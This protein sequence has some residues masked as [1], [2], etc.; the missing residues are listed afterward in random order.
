MC[1]AVLALERAFVAW[2]GE[3]KDDSGACVVLS[4][5]LP[6]SGVI[7][8]SWCGDAR[9]VLYDGKARVPRQLTRDHTAA[10]PTERERLLAAHVKVRNGRVLGVLEPTRSLGDLNLKR[11]NPRAVVAECE[12]TTVSV[13]LGAPQTAC[14]DVEPSFLVL[15][16]DGVWEGLSCQSACD[17]V[18]DAL[19]E[20]RRAGSGAE[21]HRL[22]AQTA[23]EDITSQA[24]LSTQDDCT[25]VVMLLGDR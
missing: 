20:A 13:D 23:A 10:N 24:R 6:D 22:A 15:A 12:C 11:L 2:A 25:A 9:A 7:V 16:T 3:H 17:L 4:L 1:N 19:R 8:T 14:P 5:V 21:G 18:L